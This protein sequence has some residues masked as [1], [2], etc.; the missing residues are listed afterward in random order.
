M[1]LSEIEPILRSRLIDGETMTEGPSDY[2]G[3]R[4]FT[5]TTSGAPAHAYMLLESGLYGIAT[6]DV[7]EAWKPGEKA[8]TPAINAVLDYARRNGQPLPTPDPDEGRHPT[9]PPLPTNM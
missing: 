1:H 5:I 8:A 7:F 2:Y 6:L 4:M 9:D 3:D